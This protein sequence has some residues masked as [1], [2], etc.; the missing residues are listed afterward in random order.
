MACLA[1]LIKPRQS[2]YMDRRICL[3]LSLM[4]ATAA[5]PSTERMAALGALQALDLRVGTV[6]Y[7]LATANV[8]RCEKTVRLTGLLLQDLSQ[9]GGADRASAAQF[10]GLSAMPAVT[11][12]I[13]D[14]AAAR[15][16][17]KTRDV[18]RAVNG[19][20]VPLAGTKT[21]YDRIAAIETQFEAGPV[22]LKIERDGLSRSF[23][24]DGTP[25]CASRVQVIPGRKL[26][27]SADGT[28]VQ[29]SSAVAEYAE[30][31]S[32]LASIIAH[33]MAHNILG[34]R[35]RLDAQ[36]RSAKHILETEI[37][38]DRLSVSLMKGAGFD[39]H[40][41]ARFWARFGKKTGAGIFSD[42]THQRTKARVHMLEQEATRLTQ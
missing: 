41:P 2:N 5:A 27:A 10:F 3:S 11:A 21:G 14:S 13:A 42:G 6:A 15:A 19:V 30:D 9:F 37:E 38:A 4:L 29:L 7:R 23:L 40:A 20:D 36:G 33:E 28:Y 24:I 25:A 12:M 1:S 32:A 8:A 35:A 39:P 26:N 22:T 17:V 18:V 16:G 31:D 34:H